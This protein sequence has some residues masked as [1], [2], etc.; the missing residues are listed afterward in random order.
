MKQLHGRVLLGIVMLLSLA[1]LL[2]WALPLEKEAV[3]S[4][5]QGERTITVTGYA[6]TR[7][8]SNVAYLDLGVT[9]Q[10]ADQ[11][12]AQA[13]NATKME[14]VKKAIKGMGVA[15]EDIQTSNFYISPQYDPETY[16]EIVGYEATHTLR[17]TVREVDQAGAIVD[18]ATA[19]GANQIGQISFD[20]DQANRQD[21]YHQALKEAIAKGEAKAKVIAEN[22]GVSISTPAQIYEGNASSLADARQATMTMEDAAPSQFEPGES[23]VGAYVT[24]VYHMQ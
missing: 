3:A 24:L 13:D 8:P 22:I 20:V 5:D 10:A 1:S 7:M 15:E 21:L 14:A 19:Q 16:T 12:S 4:G 2:V 6:E 17:L 11:K 18:A 9:T 23:S